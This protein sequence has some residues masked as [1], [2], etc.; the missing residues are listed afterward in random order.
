MFLYKKELVSGRECQRLRNPAGTRCAV[1]G[2]WVYSLLFQQAVVLPLRQRS[3][4]VSL[5]NSDVFSEVK[6]NVRT[7]HWDER[8][9]S[10]WRPKLVP[11]IAGLNRPPPSA[12]P[13]NFTQNEGGWS[14]MSPSHLFSSNIA[15]EAAQTFDTRIW[16]FDVVRFVNQTFLMSLFRISDQ[17]PRQAPALLRLRTE[18]CEM[19]WKI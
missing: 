14:L 16:M 8:S 4:S 18:H 6:H 3:V 13:T 9:T 15:E 5:V 12:A 2:E 7:A 11:G 1:G 17:N 10:V 19:H